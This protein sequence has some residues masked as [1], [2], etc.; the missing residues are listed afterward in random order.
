MTYQ[1][2]SVDQLIR[3][4][5]P[6]GFYRAN[7]LREEIP[8]MMRGTAPSK[9]RN[10]GLEPF[11]LRG[12]GAHKVPSGMNRMS[13]LI[14]LTNHEVGKIKNKFMKQLP[15]A[16]LK[17][18]NAAAGFLGK[19]GPIALAVTTVQEG[20]RITR[21]VAVGSFNDI[22]S[23]AKSLVPVLTTLPGIF[24]V[25]NKDSE[26][27]M[28][29]LLLVFDR[30]KMEVDNLMNNITDRIVEAF[31]KAAER[32]ID[33]GFFPA[34]IATTVVGKL[35]EGHTTDHLRKI[36]EAGVNKE[37]LTPKTRGEQIMDLLF[38][39]AKTFADA[40]KHNNN[41]LSNEIKMRRLATQY[42]E[43]QHQ[44]NLN[45]TRAAEQYY[46]GQ[47]SGPLTTASMNTL[48][49]DERAKLMVMGATSMSTGLKD[50]D[51]YSRQRNQARDM[52]EFMKIFRKQAPEGGTR[53][54]G[55]MSASDIG[56][57]M[58]ASSDYQKEIAEHTKE[59]AEATEKLNK[60][61]EMAK[62][63]SYFIR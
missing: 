41:V 39:G 45:N 14:K 12:A 55:G 37:A 24:D 18:R 8:A 36:A 58:K 60:T 51:F 17:S 4:A 23:G 5:N 40:A 7:V 54:Y 1:K 11:G 33:G 48:T 57:Q 50:A 56:R 19:L 35:T 30:V 15:K 22:S 25:I 32:V 44:I 10:F 3:A 47:M 38:E 13:A 63:G 52:R 34:D 9:F 61:L 26:I 42:M 21:D 43:E 29:M 27:G 31:R 46:K 2:R 20:F 28:K 62:F 6:A 49:A 16:I 59:T 53:A